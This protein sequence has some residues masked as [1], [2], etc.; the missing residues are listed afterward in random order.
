MILKW[1]FLPEFKN[2]QFSSVKMP[3]CLSFKLA[4][5]SCAS[6]RRQLGT[7]RALIQCQRFFLNFLM[8]SVLIQSTYRYSYLL[9]LVELSVRCISYIDFFTQQF[10]WVFRAPSPVT[11]DPFSPLLP[12][13]LSTIFL[14]RSISLLPSSLFLNGVWKVRQ[15]ACPMCARFF[16]KITTKLF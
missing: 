11:V 8:P 5:F 6:V 7:C 2:G 16:I 4:F 1:I 10:F 15:Y 14:Y 3:D 12:P 13:N 9:F